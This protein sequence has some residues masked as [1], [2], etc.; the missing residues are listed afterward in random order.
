M[1]T[2]R[3]LEQGSIDMVAEA[4]H[5]YKFTSVEIGRMLNR[6]ADVIA[7]ARDGQ[8]RDTIMS[9]KLELASTMDHYMEGR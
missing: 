6:L 8:D 4:I 7:A 3:Y 5:D 2:N 1:T 9:K